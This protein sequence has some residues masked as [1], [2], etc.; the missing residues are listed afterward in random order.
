MQFFTFRL[1]F[2]L[3]LKKKFFKK[4]EFLGYNKIITFNEDQIISFYFMFSVARTFFL[5]IPNF[6]P[7]NHEKNEQ[8]CSKKRKKHEFSANISRKMALPTLFIAF[9]CINFFKKLQKIG[10]IFQKKIVTENFSF[11][12]V[13]FGK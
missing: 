6:G 3:Y 2:F 11:G 5:E 1:I 9:L 13:F 12:G 8:K 10:N 7:K 4:L